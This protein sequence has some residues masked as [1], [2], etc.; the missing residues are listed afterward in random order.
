[1]TAAD[2]RRRVLAA[3]QLNAKQEG[4]IV[5]SEG[6]QQV[7][8]RQDRRGED[9]GRSPHIHGST[10][11]GQTEQGSRQIKAVGELISAYHSS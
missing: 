5:V 2:L 4:A 8:R 9:A 10:A 6:G 3:K 11:L 1:M 7:G